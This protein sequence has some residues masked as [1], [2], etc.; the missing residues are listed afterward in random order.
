[1]ARPPRRELAGG[2]HHVT[3]R[4]NNGDRI[5]RDATDHRIFQRLL[6]RTA[7]KFAWKCLTY[8][9]MGNHYHLLVRTEQPTLGPG[10][11]FLNGTYAQRFN[12][13]H[14]RT[15]HVWGARY[16]AVLVET[17][18]HL[19][20]AIRYIA[21]NPVRAGLC[22]RPENWS[23]G[24]HRALAGLEPAGIVAAET[25]LAYLAAN[26]GRARERYR[27]L[28]EPKAGLAPFRGDGSLDSSAHAEP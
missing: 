3:A 13:R 28:V 24:G 17:D 23:W 25:T 11:G 20:E 10:I 2:I 9:L 16:H 12:L 5:F 7:A 4:G 6:A 27:Q 15:G 19:L 18:V 26:G 8:C 21:L 1:M 14:S 22:P